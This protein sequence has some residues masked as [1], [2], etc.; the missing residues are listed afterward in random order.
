MKNLLMLAL[1]LLTIPGFAQKNKN[2]VTDVIRE[3]LPVSRKT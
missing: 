1:L 2:V 3:M